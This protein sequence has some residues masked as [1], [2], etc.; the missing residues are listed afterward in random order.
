M[1]GSHCPLYFAAAWD[2]S[3][4]PPPVLVAVCLQDSGRQYLDQATV[5]YSPTILPFDAAETE[6]QPASLN[7]HPEINKKHKYTEE[8]KNVK[9]SL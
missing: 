3:A 1:Q 9:L 6:L 4:Y 5:H 8:K 2:A 7:K